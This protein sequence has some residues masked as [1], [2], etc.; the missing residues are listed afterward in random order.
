ML[1]NVSDA[2]R[3][4][5]DGHNNIVFIENSLPDVVVDSV[6]VIEEE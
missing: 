5:T 3:V 4:K 2:W 1:Y 6:G